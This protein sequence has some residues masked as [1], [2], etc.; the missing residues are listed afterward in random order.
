MASSFGHQAA[1]FVIMIT[2]FGLFV[3]I[4][5]HPIISS[6]QS[7]HQNAVATNNR[8][9]KSMKS[10]EIMAFTRQ[11]NIALGPS[12]VILTNLLLAIPKTIFG[13]VGI[14]SRSLFPLLQGSIFQIPIIFF[15][16]TSRVGSL[17]LFQAPL[18]ILQS[19]TG[20]IKLALGTPKFLADTI[21]LIV[22]G[23]ARAVA[24]L[25][26]ILLVQLPSTIVTAA[27]PL[28]AGFIA[29]LSSVLQAVLIQ[30][31]TAIINFLG[32][33]WIWLGNSLIALVNTVLI[34]IPSLLLQSAALLG[35]IL[36]GVGA[37]IFRLV[38]I[39]IPRILANVLRVVMMAII[40]TVRLGLLALIDLVR[41]VLMA[42]N[43]GTG[44]L[45]SLVGDII[46]FLLFVLT[47][48]GITIVRSF[49]ITT[50]VAKTLLDQAVLLVF[51]TGFFLVRS[52]GFS[53]QLVNALIG[54]LA[55]K[56]LL[57]AASGRNQVL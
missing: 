43:L 30:L 50:L 8:T 14:L 55:S 7:T 35:K 48:L 40:N 5:S 15:N 34:Q 3:V 32:P 20:G 29:L 12:L 36:G 42:T 26:K 18:A 13:G 11:A 19:L 10:S 21:Y 41:S 45:T 23:S 4:Q 22:S 31:P 47:Q 33:I 24:F 53:L 16:L 39:A 2:I 52:V 44:I 28:V 6:N 57:V 56:V 1:S 49:S 27:S 46:T 38:L 51:K 54:K 17:V 9:D 25:I 37:S